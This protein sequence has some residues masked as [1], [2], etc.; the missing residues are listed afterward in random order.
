MIRSSRSIKKKKKKIDNVKCDVLFHDKN[1]HSYFLK[2][3]KHGI[4]PNDDWR[5]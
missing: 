4:L 1:R 5:K 2:T 3:P